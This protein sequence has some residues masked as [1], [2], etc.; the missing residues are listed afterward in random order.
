MDKRFM[1]E[2]NNY[3]I[4]DLE[5]IMETQQGLYDNEEMNY[6]CNALEIKKQEQ[7]T[8]LFVLTD[9]EILPEAH[10]KACDI[11]TA[12]LFRSMPKCR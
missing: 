11:L 8:D 9:E 6:I 7:K 5:L 10:R 2:I 4:S 12:T 1:E 3:S